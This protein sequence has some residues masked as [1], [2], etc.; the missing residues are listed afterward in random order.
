MN[1]QKVKLAI[2]SLLHDIGKL[3]YR[4]NDGRNH[5][6]S[7]ADYLKNELDINDPDIINQV[8]Y[9]HTSLLKTADIDNDS[10][11]YITYIADNISSA[12]DRRTNENE[13]PGFNREIPLESIFNLFKGNSQKKYYAAQQLTDVINYP[14]DVSSG[15][16]EAFYSK[17]ISHLEENL[18]SIEY[19]DE[20]LSSLLELL[21]VELSYIPSSTMKKEVAD[22]SLYDHLKLTSGISMCIYD[23]LQSNS[24]TNY[25]DYLYNNS[26][27]FYDAKAFLLFSMDI[28]GIQDF[29]YTIASKDALKMLRSR[30]FYLELLMEHSIDEL[31]SILELNRSNLLYSGGGH[32]YMI[33]PNTE[34]VLTKLRDF[35]I[36][37]NN[38]F[39]SHFNISLYMACGWQECSANELHNEPCGSYREI[40]KNVSSRISQKKVQRYTPHQ[41][42][43]MNNQTTTENTRECSV[44]HSTDLLNENNTCSICESLIKMSPQILHKGFYV[45]KESEK[46]DNTIPLPFNKCL[47][48]TNEKE[49]LKYIQEDNAKRIYTKN[50]SY[51]GVNVSKKL[52]IGDYTTN[53]SFEEFANNA[54]GINRM[55]VLRA[56]VDNLGS[57][58]INGFAN[59]KNGDKYMTISRTATFSRKMSMFFKYHIN[60]ILKKGTYYLYDNEELKQRAI[61]IVYS[62]GDDLFIVGSWDEV[63]GFA[64]DL[65]NSFEKFTQGTMSISG[66]IGIFPAK[67]PISS[68]ALQTGLLEEKSKNFDGKNAITIFDKKSTFSWNDFIHNVVEEKLHFIKQLFDKLPHKGNS[69]LYRLLDLM[70]E[71]E[72]DKINIARIAYLLS[73]VQEEIKNNED[74]DFTGMSKN[75]YCW[76]QN[77]K[78]KNELITAIYIYVYLNREISKED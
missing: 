38:W 9:H 68:M 41:I 28:S 17:I 78:D 48:A 69:F 45:V 32:A 56:D 12:I 72:N 23:W 59:E 34:D 47:I 25:K 5:S 77:S 6:I 40:F 1:N 51:T 26:N 57:A 52:W 31:L 2:G 71:L 33:L 19:T 10:L 8:K 24:I 43:L 66:G 21:E 73:R 30:S 44:C 54:T 29:I 46:K 4:Y 55:A 13:E 53:E 60:S 22:I 75:I 3:L 63:I 42:M 27:G 61:T 67:Y 15:F 37:I 18:K 50:D 11:A 14:S 7:G 49:T 36:E 39:I 58:F 20:Y 35:E 74:I 76:S 62:G 65:H 70:R 64:I 16:D